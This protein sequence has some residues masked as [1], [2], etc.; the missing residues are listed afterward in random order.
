MEAAAITTYVQ[1]DLAIGIQVILGG[2]T[3]LFQEHCVATALEWQTD[4]KIEW[5]DTVSVALVEYIVKLT[6]Y[7]CITSE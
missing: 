7:Y 6:Q 4:T 3:Y 1:E 2:N 5:L